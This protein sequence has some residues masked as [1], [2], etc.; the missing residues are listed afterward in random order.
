MYVIPATTYYYL[1]VYVENVENLRPKVDFPILLH[2]SSQKGFRK[3]V[4]GS[5]GR[6][7]ASW[8]HRT[9]RERENRVTEQTKKVRVRKIEDWLRLRARRRKIERERERE[10]EKEQ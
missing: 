10:R 9:T 3:K 4:T 6:R 5:R 7:S 1:R 2:I 8:F